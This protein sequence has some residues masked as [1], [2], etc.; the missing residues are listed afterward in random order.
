MPVNHDNAK[1]SLLPFRTSVRALVEH[2]V[3]QSTIIAVIIVNAIAIG[4]QTYPS[5]THNEFLVGLDVVV[6]TIFTIEIILRLYAHGWQFFKGGWN[7]FDL[8]IVVVS[9]LPTGGALQVLRVLRV[10]RVM[11]LLSAIPSLR[12]VVNA[13][14]ASIPGIASIGGLLVIIMYVFVVACTMLFGP[15]SSNFADLGASTVS[16]FRL[17]V[18]DGW[19]ALVE[20]LQEDLPWAWTFMMGYGVVSTFVILNLFI[21]VTTQ[22]LQEQQHEDPEPTAVEQRILDE[23]AALRGQLNK[24]T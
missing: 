5:L 14:V 24:T 18:G 4:L 17:L 10:L 13:L 2:R 11:R 20:P 9:Y 22:A 1:P 15:Y 8:I 12:K 7:W 16:L 19:G 6:L 23:L 21:A 3:F